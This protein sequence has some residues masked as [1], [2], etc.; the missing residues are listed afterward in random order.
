MKS[1]I[2]LIILLFVGCTSQKSELVDFAKCITNTGARLYGAYW[3]P[4]C[5]DQKEM[6]GNAWEYINYVEC[7]TLSGVGQKEECNQAEI[8]SYPTWV[9]SNGQRVSGQLSFQQLS[10]YTGC[11]FNSSV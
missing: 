10:E 4:H 11:V 3:C 1:A 7:S 8:D 5:Q 2:F 6:F 9:F